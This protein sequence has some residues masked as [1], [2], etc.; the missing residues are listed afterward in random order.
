MLNIPRTI[1][2]DKLDEFIN[3]YY[4]ESIMALAQQT[5]S[6]IVWVTFKDEPKKLFI[7]PS[8]KKSRNIVVGLN[9]RRVIKKDTIID[10]Y[11]ND[12]SLNTD[13]INEIQ[14]YIKDYKITKKLRSIKDSDNNEYSV[15]Y[16]MNDDETIGSPFI[17]NQ[18]SVYDAD[19]KKIAYLSIKYI[20]PKEINNFR[21]IKPYND[22]K[23]F[24][25]MAITEYSKV[26]DE[27]KRKGIGI[28]MY[29]LVAKELSK[30]KVDFRSSI[31]IIIISD[32]A[33]NLWLSLHKKYP[34]LIDKKS[35]L[36]GEDNK[37]VL[38]F[39]HKKMLK[40]RN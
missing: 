33:E 19:N 15:K 23:E 21:D 20:K 39:N 2:Y 5:E 35:M 29:Y 4:N 26:E 3:D 18:L 31:I 8:D 30:Q 24:Y 6:D 38:F 10:P 9:K 40:K 36:L 34:K 28:Q 16:V 17:S 13:K 7:M 27:Y 14:S 32:S 1:P 22:A 11:G 25:N 12:L 37:T